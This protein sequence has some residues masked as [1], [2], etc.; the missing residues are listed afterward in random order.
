[1]AFL[2]FGVRL[3]ISTEEA[4]FITLA[5]VDYSAAAAVLPL[6]GRGKLNITG[7]ERALLNKGLLKWRLVLT[8]EF[9]VDSDVGVGRVLICT[10][11]GKDA[12]RR[13]TLKLLLVL[14]D[15]QVHTYNAAFSK[16]VAQLS[17]EELPILLTHND[18]KVRSM[19]LSNIQ[20]TKH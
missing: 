4:E 5:K 15:L 10:A 13:D 20:N 1:M 3:K 19:A 9:L 11:E 2:N 6:P 8:K 12:L 7:T 16:L 14:A 17:K 18:A